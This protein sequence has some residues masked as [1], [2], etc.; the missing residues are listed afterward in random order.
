MNAP[1]DSQAGTAS[2]FD[3]ETPWFESRSAERRRS[4][5]SD[6]SSFDLI[7][8]RPDIISP[9]HMREVFHDQGR[10]IVCVSGGFD[11][12]GMH[13]VVYMNAAKKL[14]SILIVILNSDRFLYNKK[15]YYFLPAMHR[16]IIIEQ[17]RSV[18]YVYMHNP[19][20]PDDMTVCEAL[21]DIHPDIFAKG[22][23]RSPLDDPI[24]EEKVCED[25]NI[26]V[27]YGVGG[28]NKISSS[29]TL[30]EEGYKRFEKRGSK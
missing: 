23:D 8:S 11:P 1:A 9:K 12:L 3:T 19:T 27:V 10:K 28:F 22:G 21:I 24:P 29:S 16:K 20:D 15:G 25:L 18:D 7:P 4:A 5:L 6:I 30:V 2:V 13:H 17:M 26:E 14:G